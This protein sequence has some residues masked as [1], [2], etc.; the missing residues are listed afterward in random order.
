MPW[1]DLIP[2][3]AGPLVDTDGG[4]APSRFRN[5]WVGKWFYWRE[6]PACSFTIERMQLEKKIDRDTTADTPQQPR[7]CRGVLAKLKARQPVT[8]VTM[9]DSLSDKRHWANRENLWWE[10][11]TQRI[12]TP[13]AVRSPWSIRRSAERRSARM[14]C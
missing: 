12:R 10:I 14:S 13:T 3:L 8:V 2:E 6:H 11:L 4:Y 9:G 7:G 1:N 5:V